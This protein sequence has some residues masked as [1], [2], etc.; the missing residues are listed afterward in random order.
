MDS[1]RPLRRATR[2]HPRRRGLGARQ[3]TAIVG[4]CGMAAPRARGR[5]TEGPTLLPDLVVGGHVSGRDDVRPDAGVTVRRTARDRV[6]QSSALWMSK[7][8]AGR[9]RAWGLGSPAGLLRSPETVRVLVVAGVASRGPLS[10]S[11]DTG[12]PKWG[13]S[14]SRIVT[15]LPVRAKQDS[16]ARRAGAGENPHGGGTA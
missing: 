11:T 13:P 2:G 14:S 8:P 10:T 3:A 5:E 6:D 1:S 16:R 4:E 9:R 15:S 12:V 7:T